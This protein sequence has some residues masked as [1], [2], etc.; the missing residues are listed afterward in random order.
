[1][2][3]SIKEVLELC[4]INDVDFEMFHGLNSND[5]IRTTMLVDLGETIRLDFGD[6][7]HGQLISRAHVANNHKLVVKVSD[8]MDAI[9]LHKNSNTWAIQ[10][11]EATENSRLRIPPTT[12]AS[13]VKLAVDGVVLS[14]GDS[15]W[16]AMYKNKTYYRYVVEQKNFYVTKNDNKVHEGEPSEVIIFIPSTETYKVGDTIYFENGVYRP[17]FGIFFDK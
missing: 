8:V 3:K 10:N 15:N 16:S 6:K 13:G 9:K 12:N 14:V 4:V 11:K 2:S 1:M 17:G 5:Q 7:K